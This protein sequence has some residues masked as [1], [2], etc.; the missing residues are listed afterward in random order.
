[1]G[2][3]SSAKHGSKPNNKSNR[4]ERL[5]K[6]KQKS[7]HEPAECSIVDKIDDSVWITPDLNEIASKRVAKWLKV[8]LGIVWGF[9]LGEMHCDREMNLDQEKIDVEFAEAMKD[10]GYDGDTTDI[11]A[12][13]DFLIDRGVVGWKEAPALEL[14]IEY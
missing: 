14:D 10:R 8:E 2:R 6:Q 1:M 4:H 13:I 12:I 9:F 7:F 11:P 5:H 3:N